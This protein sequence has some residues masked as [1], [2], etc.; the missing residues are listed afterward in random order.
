MAVPPDVLLN[1]QA[2]VS[3]HVP[4]RQELLRRHPHLVGELE[5]YF[6]DGLRHQRCPLKARTKLE[7]LFKLLFDPQTL[8]AIVAHLDRDE[9]LGNSRMTQDQ[10]RTVALELLMWEVH[11]G[12]R[13]DSAADKQLASVA[14]S[15]AIAE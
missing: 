15:A 8:D 1:F 3:S 12:F 2:L 7:D 11:Q 4:G 9:T 13:G 6:D 10:L 5:A 14:E